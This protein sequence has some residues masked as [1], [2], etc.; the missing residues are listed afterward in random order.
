MNN[1]VIL[2]ETPKYIKFVWLTGKLMFYF[3]IVLLVSFIFHTF[4]YPYLTFAIG[5]CSIL[6]GI[7]LIG[8]AKMLNWWETGGV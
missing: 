1:K 8:I 4:T 6:L 3:G 2:N 5:G 7:V